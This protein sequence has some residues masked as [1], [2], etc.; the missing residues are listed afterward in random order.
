MLSTPPR[1][2]HAPSR[3]IATE[4]AFTVPEVTSAMRE[5]V[6]AGGADLDL[7]LPIVRQTYLPA[8]A[9][10]VAEP[11][12]APT[13]RDA[14]SAHMLPQ[15]LELGVDRLARMD[16]HGVDMHVLSLTSPGV[17]C[18]ETTLAV[19]LARV[20]NDRLADAVRAH[21]TRFAGLA[22][23]APQD[24]QAAAREMERTVNQLGLHGF[25]INSHTNG[26]YLDDPFFWPILEAAQAL[27]KPIYLHP[28]APSPSLGGPLRDYR[29]EGAAW[30]FGVETATHVLRLMFSGTLDRFPNLTL[31]LGHM[32]E[33]LPFWRW[34]LDFMGQPG[35]RAERRNALAP[36]DYL[37]RNIVV[38]SS[39]VEDPRA[40]RYT[41]DTLG[42]DRVMWAIDHPYQ[43]TAPAVAFLENAPLSSHEHELFS[44]GNAERVFGL[45][46]RG[47]VRYLHRP[48]PGAKLE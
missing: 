12:L 5:I 8:V 21:P 17:Q 26:R 44:C 39:G 35:S 34:R 2:P 36:S 42:V 23:I 25:V 18:L 9:S 24:P 4:E 20:A 22:S 46:A 6:L 29:L 38:T 40:L 7:D 19:A 13:E 16:A 3:R 11:T 43:P 47:D 33:G 32:G 37:A 30:G 45:T 48:E 31:V 10:A 41:I 28:R 14:W 15:L 1:P 27:R